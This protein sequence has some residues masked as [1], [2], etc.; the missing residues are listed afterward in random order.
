MFFLYCIQGFSFCIFLFID[1]HLALKVNR[2]DEGLTLVPQDINVLVTHLILKDNEITRITNTSLSLYVE[3]NYIDLTRNGLTYIEDGAFD[4]IGK[5]KK[6]TATKNDIKQ[7][8][9]SFGAATGSLEDIMFW[10]ALHDS[11]TT[12]LNF[13]ELTSLVNINI[14]S[15][16]Y[17]GV[18]NAALLPRNLEWICI[19]MG[20]LRYFPDFASYTPNIQS[21][22]L[23][24]ND[25]TYIPEIAIVGLSAL[26][27]LGINE[28]SLFTLPDLFHLPMNE[29]ALRENLLECNYSLCWLRMWPWL[30]QPL[31]VDDIT[32]NSPYTL[33]GN[34]LMDIHPLKLGCHD[35]MNII[36]QRSLL[37]CR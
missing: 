11:I 21:I 36:F 12:K 3:L 27:K 30:K 25:I 22:I 14:G 23:A 6:I 19:N 18:F 4:S 15:S 10:A 7:L 35:G 20:K 37:A 29:L 31:N 9:Q 5:L 17:N 24:R 16:D 2:E 13:T 8:P 34:R 26:R 1:M 28:N 32:C 33:Q